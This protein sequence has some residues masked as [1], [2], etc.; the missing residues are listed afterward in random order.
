MVRS[1][2][3]AAWAAGLLSIAAGTPLLAGEEPRPGTELLARLLAQ[4]GSEPLAAI[5]T[6][7]PRALPEALA[8]TALGRAFHDPQ[9]A[10]GRQ[11]LRRQTGELAGAELDQVWEGLRPHLAGPAALVLTEGP[12]D[13]SLP[14]LRLA[15]LLTVADIQA[16]E[17]VRLAWPRVPP[18]AGALLSV[19]ALK[20]FTPGQLAGEAAP[21][22]WAERAA[23]LD[24]ALRVVVRPREM[25]GLL[26][27][28]FGGDPGQ[29]SPEW[30]RGLRSL[31]LDGIERLEL[32][33]Q[34]DAEYFLEDLR[35]EPAAGA[36]GRATRLL[37]G[38][39]AD[40]QPWDALLAALPGKQDAILL[41]QLN[42]AALGDDL[43]LV[44][45]VVERLARGE[46]WWQLRGNDP[47]ARAAERFRFLTQF[48]SGTAGI[49]SRP[50][51]S[52][53]AET[54]AVAATPGADVEKVRA[55]LAEGLAELGAPFETQEQA[56]RIGNQ[57]PL[58]ASFRGRGFLPAPVLGLSHGWVWLCSNTS[59]YQDLVAAFAAGGQTLSA[60]AKR[61]E[62]F[63]PAT[64]SLAA[65]PEH[66]AARLRL[67]LP[68]FFP[69]LYT[70][71]MLGEQG[72]QLF[73]WKVPAELLPS[74]GFL[75]RYLAPYRAEMRWEGT[76]VR[77]CARGPAPG[78]ALF[79]LF[80]VA[81]VAGQLDEMQRSR[82][83]AL[84]KQLEALT[85]TPPAEGPRP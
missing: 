43:P 69:L 25:E 28:W 11:E 52:G 14:R 3:R 21:P 77:V 40:P 34:T 85:G 67:N 38:L 60:E 75:K 57:P 36:G 72:P 32:E 26:K 41:A 70:S 29:A 6:P 79:P 18:D 58:A 49:V 80:G 42:L 46:K 55:A 50:G 71:W 15:L 4:A 51:L 30:L 33:L 83:E 45:Q 54:V 35:C 74:P 13:A 16:A 39:R 73:G 76:H 48:A 59:A 12:K 81:L 7:D 23:K 19:A 1:L 5:M 20:V 9:Y 84:R 47:E 62:G 27:T 10:Q 82:P 68:K 37:R 17:G 66:S 56:P 2:V 64:W 22:A 31:G 8:R 24:G 44:W 65:P 61:G 63:W 78:G 53:E